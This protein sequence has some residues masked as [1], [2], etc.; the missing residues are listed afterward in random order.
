MG[1]RTVGRTSRTSVSHHCCCIANADP[2]LAAA[3]QYDAPRS[4]GYRIAGDRR[5]GSFEILPR[6]RLRSQNSISSP[7]IQVQARDGGQE[8]VFI[9]AKR[10]EAPDTVTVRRREQERQQGPARIARDRDRRPWPRRRRGRPRDRRRASRAGRPGRARVGKGRRR[11][12]PSRSPANAPI[13]RCVSAISGIRQF[14]SRFVTKPGIS[15]TSIGPD[16]NTWNAR[17]APSAAFA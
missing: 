11:A 10:P 17:Y 8:V 1:V 6:E 7:T 16:P 14:S 9:G 5:C 4:D 3:R 2:G 12:G 15:S 13:R